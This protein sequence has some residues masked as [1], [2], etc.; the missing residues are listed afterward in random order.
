MFDVFDI[1][2]FGV[3]A[4]LIAAFV[5]I[6]VTLGQLPGQIAKRRGHPQAAAIN[7]LGWVG[8][9]TGVLWL[10]ALTWAFM[11]PLPES[12]S[13]A[14]KERDLSPSSGPEPVGSR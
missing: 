9:L 12:L 2:V 14:R 3:F 6:V 8:L 10:L 7:V 4:V 11:K 5:V 13:T 1:L